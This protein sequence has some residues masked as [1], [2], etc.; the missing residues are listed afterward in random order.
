MTMDVVKI[1]RAVGL[2]LLTLPLYRSHTMQPLDV[3]CFKPFKQAFCLLRDIWTLRNKSK[4][5]SKEVLV[6]WVSSALTK[7]LTH[8]NITSGFQTT[9]IFPFNPHAM[10]DKNR[11]SEFYREVPMITAA[12]MPEREAMDL[13]ALENLQGIS[14]TF[15]AN[16]DVNVDGGPVAVATQIGGG[17]S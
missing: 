13:G 7:A 12:C 11:P 2:D 8:K 15:M 9:G 3:S 6:T 14:G 5:A 4:G 1:A 17:F 16:V 10:Q